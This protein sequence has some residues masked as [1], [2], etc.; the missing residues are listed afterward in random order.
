MEKHF[1]WLL[2]AKQCR[3]IWKLH[4]KTSFGTEAY[5]IGPK[6]GSWTCP[7]CSKS[8]KWG[9]NAPEKHN[10]I[11]INYFQS[12]LIEV[13]Y[14]WT[15]S[16]LHHPALSISPDFLLR[17]IFKV[18]QTPFWKQFWTCGCHSASCWLQFGL[19]CKVTGYKQGHGYV[20][21]YTTGQPLKFDIVTHFLLFTNPWIRTL[22]S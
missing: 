5:E 3:I 18:F 1:F 2:D 20:S 22:I 12:F 14:F 7:S 15:K 6:A 10:F 11:K 4:Q 19:L 16:Y 21:P 13:I 17:I 8:S 9:R